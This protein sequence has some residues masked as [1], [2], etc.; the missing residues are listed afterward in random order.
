MPVDAKVTDVKLFLIKTH[1]ETLK[2]HSFVH[3][4]IIYEMLMLKRLMPVKIS[5]ISSCQVRTLHVASK[6]VNQ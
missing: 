2:E 1:F 5:S 3:F 6:L 4:V